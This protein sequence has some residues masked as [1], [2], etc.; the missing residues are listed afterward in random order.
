MLHK[1][2]VGRGSV[3]EIYGLNSVGHLYR[4]SASAEWPWERVD[5]TSVGAVVQ[6]VA[7]GE[8]HVFAVDALGS[9]HRCALPCDG[10]MNRWSSVQ[11]IS[12]VVAL[13]ATW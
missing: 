2:S 8:A 9:V 1:V 3:K 4:N 10:V 5:T 7:V 12:N 6:D 13:D 11:S